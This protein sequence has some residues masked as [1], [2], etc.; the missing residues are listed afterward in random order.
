MPLVD[1]RPGLDGLRAIAVAL[2]LAF[3]L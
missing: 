1:Y 2:V 3:H